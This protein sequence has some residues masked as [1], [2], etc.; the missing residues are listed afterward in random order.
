MLEKQEQIE[1]SLDQLAVIESALHTQS[2]ILDVQAAA[3]GISARQRLNEI[4]TLL[5][6]LALHA[7]AKPARRTGARRWFGLTRTI[8]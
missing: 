3:G 8:G 6:K 5:A 7:P 1:F 2:K 4:K